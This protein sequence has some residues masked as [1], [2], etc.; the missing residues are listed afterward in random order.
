MELRV[1][2]VR[3]EQD[4]LAAQM[5]PILLILMAEHPLTRTEGGVAVVAGEPH[6]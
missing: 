4:V 6:L 5:E 3:E 1:V 2:V